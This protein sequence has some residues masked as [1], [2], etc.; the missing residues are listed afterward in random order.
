MP[1]DLTPLL[2][3]VPVWLMILFRLTGIFVFAPVLGSQAIPRLIKVF[4]A[5][6]LSFAVWPMLW[7]DPAVAENLGTAMGSLNLWSLGLLIGF[8]LLV[9][10]LIGYAASL[11]MVGMQLGGHMIDQQMGLAV[12]AIFNP[13]AGTES[14]AMGQLLFMFALALFVM[15]GGLEVMLT[16]LAQSFRTVPPGGMTH[17]A[18]IAQFVVGLVTV[19][20]ELAIK[21]SAPVL[22]LMF[23]TSAGMGFIMR[24]VPQMNI[25]S[26]GFS[27]RILATVALMAV[28]VG[29]LSGAYEDSATLT[30]HRLMRFFTIT[31]PTFRVGP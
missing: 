27:V 2:P 20:F 11:P 3:Y 9:G 15:A 12:G 8:E 16:T 18:Q 23:L 1:V 25:L 19:M 10:Y 30:F 4:L 7:R 17:H 26:V 31:P 13:E 24:T 6:G 21:V 22:C 28:T 5:L 29:A 14:A